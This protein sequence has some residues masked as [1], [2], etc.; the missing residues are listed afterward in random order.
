M[1]NVVS[2]NHI[3]NFIGRYIHMQI[4]YVRWGMLWVQA[5]FRTLLV[6]IH[7]TYVPSYL[8]REICQVQT[9]FSTLFVDVQNTQVDQLHTL[10]N[11]L[12]LNLIHNS[13]G[14]YTYVDHLH[15]LRNAVSMNPIQN[16]I[17]TY[18]SVNFITLWLAVAKNIMHSEIGYKLTNYWITSC[19]LTIFL[20]HIQLWKYDG[21]TS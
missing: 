7:Y 20:I 8:H 18:R 3:Q 19:A 21:W 1:R 5:I 15:K 17:G 11:V 14:R 2:T 12:S 6:D 10:R 16:F 9:L 13:I 4:S